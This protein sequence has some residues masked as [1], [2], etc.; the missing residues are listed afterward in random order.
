VCY[1]GSRPRLD[2]PDPMPTK[3]SRPY[4]SFPRRL[5][6]YRPNGDCSKW[7]DISE[8]ASALTVNAF[9]TRSSFSSPPPSPPPFPPTKVVI[10]QTTYSG[11]VPNAT[12]SDSLHPS[13]IQ[14]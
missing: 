8:L 9:H 13:D 10:D 3:R 14:N 5:K 4:Y 1:A 7:L 6:D 12:P 2:A 11:N